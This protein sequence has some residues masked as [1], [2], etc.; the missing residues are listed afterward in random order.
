MNSPNSLKRPLPASL[1]K[2][3]LT[4]QT[5]LVTGACGQLGS[6]FCKVLGEAGAKVIVSDLK[7]EACETR[8]QSLKELEVETGLA[9]MDVTDPSSVRETFR[10]IKQENKSLDILVNA[11]AIAVFSPFEERSYEEFMRVMQVNVGGLFLCCQEA[12]RQMKGQKTG[13]R[14]INISSIYGMVS[15]DPRIYTDCDRVSSEVYASSK[16]AVI[17]LTRYLAIHLAPHKIRVNAISP[18]GVYN[19]QGPDFVK[20]YSRRTPMDRM[21]NEEE[22]NGALLYLASKASSYVTGHNL[23]VDGGLTAW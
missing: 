21:A 12:A 7:S 13:G 1:E 10:Q 18:G 14:I 4:G 11:A 6:Q 5:A 20:N 23:V 8:V 19:H 15:C 16:A 17:M 3:D 2:F 9:V 22:M